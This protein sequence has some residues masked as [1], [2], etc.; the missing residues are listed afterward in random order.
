MIFPPINEVTLIYQGNHKKSMK[1]QI[2]RPLYSIEGVGALVEK[3]LSNSCDGIKPIN[4]IKL[5][6]SFGSLDYTSH[7]LDLDLIG[8]Y[9][10]NKLRGEG[11]S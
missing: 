8:S 1:C 7:N 6:D 3:V 2:E 10:M 4:Q 5:A 11:V 9:K